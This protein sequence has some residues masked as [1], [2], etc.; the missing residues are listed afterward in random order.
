MEWWLW[1][2]LI[3][4]SLVVLL[5]SGM[6]VAFCFIAINVVGAFVLWAGEAGLSQ[7]PLN[8]YQSVTLFSLFPLPLFILMGEVLFLSKIGV[9]VLSALDNWLGRLPGRLGL[10]AV[11]EGTII[12]ALS[13]SS[14]GSCAVLGSLLTP[15]MEKTRV[16]KGD[17]PRTHHGQWRAGYDNSSQC[18]GCSLSYLRQN[19][20]GKSAHSRGHS[21][22]D[23]G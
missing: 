1:L 7:L 21:W 16:Q 18:P 5:L 2:V 23:N 11:A 12:A 20:C 19:P 9:Y 14:M 17:E 4:G 3:F 13:G 10:L 8:M 22:P 6:P 15:E